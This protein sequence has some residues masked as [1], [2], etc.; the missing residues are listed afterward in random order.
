MEKNEQ[1]DAGNKGMKQGLTLF[2]ILLQPIL[3]LGSCSYIS[4]NLFYED[5]LTAI[6]HNN[7]GVAY[8]REGKYDLAKREYKMAIEK[9]KDFTVS[10]INL[11]NV[12]FTTGEL[13][14]AEKQYTRALETDP[15]NTDAANNLGNVYLKKGKHPETA[16]EILSERMESAEE[17]P[18]YYLDTL[19]RLY[20]ES[21]NKERGIALLKKA[22]K[23]TGDEKLKTSIKSYLEDLGSGS[24]E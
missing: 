4:A 16:I 2:I 21:G 20:L 10:I 14:K 22:C 7:L 18:D 17:M 1:S 23:K 5:P 6:E 11:G 8:E 3:L 9:K 15:D 19:G 12:Y 13:D 24:C